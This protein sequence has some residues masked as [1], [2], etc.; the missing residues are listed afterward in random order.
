MF[1]HDTETM[2]IIY[3]KAGFVSVFKLADPR[4]IRQITP[5]SVHTFDHDQ[6]SPFAIAV[7]GL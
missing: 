1:P 2:R 6:Y 5:H 7:S 4:Q 3:E